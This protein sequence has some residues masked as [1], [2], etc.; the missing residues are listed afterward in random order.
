MS[1]ITSQAIRFVPDDRSIASFATMTTMGDLGSIFETEVLEDD[2][3]RPRI[4]SNDNI[5]DR[6]VVD[7]IP[8]ATSSVASGTNPGPR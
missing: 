1:G 3:I 2:D 4:F 5:I 8:E 7:V 6:T